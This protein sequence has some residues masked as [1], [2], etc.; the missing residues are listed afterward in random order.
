MIYRNS[1][2]TKYFDIQSD[3]YMQ[4]SFKLYFHP[5]LPYL[6]MHII[7]YILHAL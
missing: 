2:F 7:L 4:I 6:N 1:K 3:L 5:S